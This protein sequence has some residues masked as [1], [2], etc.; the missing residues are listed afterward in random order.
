MK[1][2]NEKTKVL[3]FEGKGTRRVKIAVNNKME[4]F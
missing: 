2:S 3:A 1:I 4:K